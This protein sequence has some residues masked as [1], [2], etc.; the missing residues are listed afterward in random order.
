MGGV[1][2][3]LIFGTKVS[4][5]SII[6]QVQLLFTGQQCNCDGADNRQYY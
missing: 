6:D 1:I 3:N 2:L 4:A 5:I